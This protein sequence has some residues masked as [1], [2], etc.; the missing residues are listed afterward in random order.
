ML[1]DTLAQK[2]NNNHTYVCHMQGQSFDISPLIQTHIFK[3][4]LN[5]KETSPALFKHLDV[6]QMSIVSPSGLKMFGLVTRS[7]IE[8]FLLLAFWFQRQSHFLTSHFIN[9]T[10]LPLHPS[11]FSSVHMI[12][13]NL[14]FLLPFHCLVCLFFSPISFTWSYRC[15]FQS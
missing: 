15:L 2:K 14:T 8:N 7:C 10:Y 11:L 1:T 3:I 6:I 5:K 13:A 9:A 4:Y 12:T